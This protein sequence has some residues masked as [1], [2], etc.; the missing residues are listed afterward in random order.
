[1]TSGDVRPR[2]PIRSRIRSMIY[3]PYAKVEIYRLQII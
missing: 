2:S 1:M 3:E